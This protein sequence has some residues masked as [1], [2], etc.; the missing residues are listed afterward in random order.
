MEKNNEW[1]SYPHIV[2]YPDFDR[3]VCE[4][5]VYG[6][7]NA[8]GDIAFLSYDNGDDDVRINLFRTP[9]DVTIPLPVLLD[10]IEKGRKALLCEEE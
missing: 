7:D 8:G 5:S 6:P 1:R 9:D 4:I 2:S 3:V 10:A